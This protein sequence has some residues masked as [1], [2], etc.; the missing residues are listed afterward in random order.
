MGITT[1]P[2][3]DTRLRTVVSLL[4][5]FSL[6]RMGAQKGRSLRPFG[7][8][9]SAALSGPEGDGVYNDRM[10]PATLGCYQAVLNGAGRDMM[11]GLLWPL[12]VYAFL[13]LAAVAGM[14]TVSHVLGERRT[15]VDLQEP[16]ESGI[17][18]SASKGLRY[19]VKFYLVAMFFVIFDIES[20]FIF[21]WAISFRE[22]R[23]SGYIEIAVFVGILL[24]ALF[25]LWRV[26]ALDS[27]L[28]RRRPQTLQ[29]DKAG[30]HECS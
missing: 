17:R 29:K 15:N 18:A 7:R 9:Q 24:V 10:L 26:G 2:Y 11:L 27:G 1:F 20:I 19:S 23:W 16:Y 30:V 8:A 12:V 28:V 25:Y 21:A 13:A 3:F 22:V 6:V 5:W 4:L 14:I